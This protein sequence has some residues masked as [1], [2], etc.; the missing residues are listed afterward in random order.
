MDAI[1]FA[2]T[3]IIL[4]TSGALAPG[5]LFFVTISHGIKSGTKSGII[6]SITHTMIEFSLVFFL[7]LGLL[8][9]ANQPIIKFTVGFAGGAVL[10]VFGFLQVRSS[11]LIKNNKTESERGAFRKLFLIGLALT[12]L[13]PYF[14][15]WWLTIGANL[16]LLSLEFAGLGGVLFM[17]ACHVWVD[18]VWLILLS[19]LAKKGNK[20]L[21]HRWYRLV[22]AIFGIIL[23]L[24]GF[25]F[26]I[27]SLTF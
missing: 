5:P 6:F 18:Y 14:V 2:I 27:D 9:I 23:I 8:S 26:I 4:T 17:Y 1:T 11:F 12:G 25:S 7:A 15:I 16:I 21:K 13:N 24:F 19:A 10:V 22:I 3:V 20:I